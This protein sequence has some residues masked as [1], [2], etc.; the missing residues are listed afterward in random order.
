MLKAY[1]RMKRLS[2]QSL[3]LCLCVCLVVFLVLS[4]LATAIMSAQVSTPETQTKD[5]D[6]DTDKEP[7]VFVAAAIEGG[8][9]AWVHVGFDSSLEQKYD[10][11]KIFSAVFGCAIRDVELSRDEGNQLTS[12]DTVCKTTIQRSFMVR[13]GTINL[14]PIRDIQ[15]A[16]PDVTFA[17]NL[18]FSQNQ[19]VR[20]QPDSGR[21]PHD[22]STAACMYFF[23]SPT[24]T[25]A[26]IHYEFG[27]DRAHAL[28][29]AAILGFL[30][31]IPIVLTFWFRRRASTA[32]EEARPAVSFAYRRFLTRMVLL[33][34]LIWWA[35]LDL[36]KT[37][38]FLAFLVP[39]HWDRSSDVGEMFPW[40]LLWIPPAIIY[41]ICLALSSP[42]HNLRGTNVTPAQILNRAFWSVVRF[43]I[44]LPMIV[45]GIAQA[46]SNPRIGV[47]LAAAGFVTLR[48]ANARFLRV[49]GIEFYALTSGEL[50]DR[51]FAVAE[52]ANT[53]L[54]QLY[55]FPMAAMRIANAFAHSAQNVFLTDYLV[56]NLTKPEVDAV[57][58]HEITHLQKKHIGLR[59]I[60]MIFLILVVAS[61]GIFLAVELPPNLPTGPILYA[62][63]LLICFFLLRRNEFAADAGS[64]RLTGN[65]EAMMTALA[66]I[67]RLNSMPLQW[68]KLDE[69]LLTHPST[70]RRI[71]RL[72]D[73]AGISESR[74]A[75]LLAQSF[76]PPQET[77]S[78]PPTALPAGKVFSTRYKTQLSWKIA[79]AIVLVS[80]VIPAIVASIGRWAGFE[81]GMRASTYVLGLF[82]TLAADWLLLNFMP[83]LG[84]AK[85][86]RRFR[87]KCRIQRQN[88]SACTG[89]FVGLVPDSSQRIYEGNWSW[90][91]G[92]LSIAQD[93][94]SYW[95]EEAKFVLHRDQ[96]TSI[97]IGPGPAGWLPAPSIYFS[98]RDSAG[99]SGTFNLRPLAASSMRG[100]SAKTRLLTRDLENW[101]NRTPAPTNPIL[102][103][104]GPTH[105]A[106]GSP[107]F[108]QVTGM[109]PRTVVRGRVFARDFLLNSFVAVA[110]I[111][112]F[113]LSFPPLDGLGGSAAS[114]DVN[115]AF[116]GI[117][118][119][120]V[121]WLTRAF[122]FIP[123]WRVRDQSH[124]TPK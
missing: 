65:A 48:L 41:F 38:E 50:R 102:A 63:L 113:G 99:K 114:V 11:P 14:Q 80:A 3:P 23:E 68:S 74:T 53:K 94:L 52:K 12:F 55:V 34:S 93:E 76:L 21:S 37:N 103:M 75:E 31:L 91:V 85:L 112:V 107:A 26:V 44:P 69:K 49:H 7:S 78:I 25:P 92:L 60:V 46:F 83:M 70:L 32:P 43:L 61:S 20:C 96:I 105:E 109:S 33:G 28:L 72:A 19:F 67:T 82:L 56:N 51:A 64:A 84:V 18:S 111:L 118:V 24:G 110:V 86:E 79:W 5:V 121:V 117:Y 95:G 120:V 108:G 39:I 16:D 36:L 6:S 29:L 122:V 101:L 66:R 58:A 40:I 54:N 27:Y 59:I 57:I 13:S 71:K 10:F 8:G 30:L 73:N 89:V 22:P 47:P 88:A 123:Y 104:S 45:F 42:M 87:E 1:P 77:Y 15:S 62:M 90:D 9:G 124:P 4:P 115:A 17:F 98:W 97:S 106:A 100:M 116:G 2:G 35:A 81:G 119:L